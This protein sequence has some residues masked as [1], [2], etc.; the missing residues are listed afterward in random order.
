MIEFGD[1]LQNNAIDLM[2]LA[3]ESVFLVMMVKF[4][5]TLLR[6]LRASQEQLGA[7]L[8][9]DAVWVLP[10]SPRTREQ[11]QWLAA[12]ITELGGEASL[13]TSDLIYATD[14]QA[15]RRQFEEPVEAAYRGILKG[16][17]RKNRDLAALSK[18]FQQTQAQDFFQH[19]LGPQVRDKL[20]TAHG[21]AT[22]RRKG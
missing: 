3:I 11:F 17:T 4:S 21:G 16:L 7:L 1:W 14:E 2:R 18:Q 10:E 5:R 15:L 9:Q 22:K 12:E 8:L 20:L 13:W 6:T 19:K